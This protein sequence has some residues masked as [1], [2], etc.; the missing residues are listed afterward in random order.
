M[1]QPPHKDSVAEQPPASHLSKPS[2]SVPS[3]ATAVPT[4]PRTTTRNLSGVG[5]ARWTWAAQREAITATGY[6]I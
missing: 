4:G 5:S 1:T 2:S 6:A 3:T